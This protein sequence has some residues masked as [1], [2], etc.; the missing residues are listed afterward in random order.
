MTGLLTNSQPKL[1]HHRP[2]FG[3]WLDRPDWLFCDAVAHAKVDFVIIDREH[4]S[5][6]NE[7]VWEITALLQASG[8]STYV[9]VQELSRVH[10]MQALDWG[11]DAVIIPGIRTPDE[12]SLAIDYA[13]YPPAGSRGWGPR[14][15]QSHMSAL[16]DRSAHIHAETQKPRVLLQIETASAV[17]T[18]EEIVQLPGLGGVL[19]GPMDLSGEIASLGNVD[20]EAMT[21]AVNRTIS[22]AVQRGIAVGVVEP[23]AS[24]AKLQSRIDSGC[25]FISIGTQL[26]LIH[27]AVTGRL[28]SVRQSVPQSPGQDN[29]HTVDDRLHPQEGVR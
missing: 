7:S 24:I 23:S 29:H 14:R 8:V 18:I 27:D 4:G 26:G 10:V 12:A 19:I 5:F 17:D 6:S 2:Q 25:S 9:R 28:E 20:D 16:R 15:I 13:T 22:A 11:A 1:N 21:L 3:V